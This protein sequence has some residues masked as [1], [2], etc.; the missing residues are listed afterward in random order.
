MHIRWLLLSACSAISLL[1]MV[2]F[3][4]IALVVVTVQSFSM[5]PTLKHGDRVLVF[6]YWPASW[7]RKGHIVIVQPPSPDMRYLTKPVPFIKRVIGLPGDTLV[8][9]LSQLNDHYRAPLLSAH[10]EEG[11]RI[12]HVPPGHLF[13]RGDYVLG[14]SDS[15]TWGP[16]PFRSVLGIVLMKLSRDPLGNSNQL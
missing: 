15:L 7:L 2:V 6:R 16:I 5:S 14:G 11:K 8:T 9:Y 1:I 12:W 4:R 3:I 13:V 10:D